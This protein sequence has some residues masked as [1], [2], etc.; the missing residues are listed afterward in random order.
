MGSEVSQSHNDKPP[1]F[2]LICRNLGKSK[3][4]RGHE[5]KRGTHGGWEEEGKGKVGG[6]N[7]KG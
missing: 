1:M 6:G 2:S 4:N 5:S 7:K 3:S